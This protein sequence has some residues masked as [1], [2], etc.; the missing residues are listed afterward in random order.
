M[1]K[2][3]QKRQKLKILITGASRGI[4]RSLAKYYKDKGYEVYGVARDE[5]KLKE[6]CDKYFSCDLSNLDEV[7]EVSKKLSDVKFDI[8]ILNAGISTPHSR[9]FPPIDAFK[10]VF[11]V[12]LLSIHALLEYIDFKDSKL[13]FI[14]S[15]AS[16]LGAPTS[17]AYSASKR[18][19][20]SYAESLYFAGVD[21]RL[22]LPG[23]I[24]TDMTKNHT[25]YM[26][27]LM[28]LDEA[29]KK[30]VKII[31]KDKFFN[32]FPL[33]FYYII[34]LFKLLPDNLKRKIL[35]KYAK[36]DIVE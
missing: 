31:E 22:I 13:V 1:I 21:V 16:I 24:K 6:I 33:R 4:G 19:L 29:T 8:I 15:L 23:F 35:K 26:P 36:S 2:S 20:N 10:K 32:P 27:F 25:F 7:S 3:Y 34:K 11:D 28:D 18:A 17:L 30:I 5:E 12:N 14:S 9:D